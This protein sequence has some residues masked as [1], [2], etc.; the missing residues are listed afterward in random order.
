V[1]EFVPLV[2]ATALVWRLVTFGKQLLAGE[3]RAAVTQVFVWAA[4]I[5]VA[6]LLAAS[7]FAGGVEVAGAS[8]EVLNAASLVLFGVALGSTASTA[9]EFKKAFDQTDSATEPKPSLS[10]RREP[11][12]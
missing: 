7:D 3:L 10:L 12:S 6:F 2:V 9:Y 4:G 5:G 11:T 1:E 8:L